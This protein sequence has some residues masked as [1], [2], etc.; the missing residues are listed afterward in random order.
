MN[1]NEIYFEEIDSTSTYIKEHFNQ[2]DN[3]T[4][5]ST[6]FQ[7]KGRGRTNRV[8]Y[9]NKKE[10]IMFSFLILD[11]SLIKKYK[12]LSL[13][14]AYVLAKVIKRIYPNLSIKIKWPNDVYV[15]KNKIS[16][17]LLESHLNNQVIDGIIVGIGLNC[18]QI[19]FPPDLIYP[20]TSLK[21]EL[22]LDV[23]IYSLRTIIEEELYSYLNSLKENNNEHIL[24]SR[25]NNYLKDKE[26]YA[27]INNEK[28][29]I[30]VIDIN[31][32]CSLKIKVD[33]KII[34]IISG[35]ITFH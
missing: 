1:I 35:E 28:K 26:V 24:F 22:N 23:D 12:D 25:N 27:T 14:S 10:N 31:D 21:K 5:V 29:L 20:V 13:A 2:L 18:N 17:I 16:G 32:D 9:S 7:S 6:S 33:D 3:F 30:K 4:F 15:N 19:T 8:W 11:K 34:N